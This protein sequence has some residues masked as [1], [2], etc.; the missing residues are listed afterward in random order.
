MTERDGS[1][2]TS[3]VSVEGTGR[4]ARTGKF[5]VEP[6]GHRGQGVQSSPGDKCGRRA[7]C[8]VV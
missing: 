3:A 4:P 6:T 7:L 8:R 2:T 1:C 5:K